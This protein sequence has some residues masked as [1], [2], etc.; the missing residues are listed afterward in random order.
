M[1]NN[2]KTKL[3]VAIIG[4][5]PIGLAAAARLTMHQQPFILF[6][7]GSQVGANFLDYHHVRLFTPWKYNIDNV[8]KN[9]LDQNGWE[10][11]KES[12]LP[13]GGDV[14]SEYLKPLADLSVLKPYIHV[15]SEV[16]SIG[17]TKMDKVKKKGRDQR[18]F[19]IQVHENNEYKSYE[20]KA[21][22]DASGVWQNH[23]PIGSEGINA[24]GE[25]KQS[26]KIYY[27]I[28]DVLHRDR[29]RYIGKKTLVVGGGHSAINTLLDLAKLQKKDSDTKLIWVLRKSTVNELY[30][31]NKKD[32]L[33]ARG[34]LGKRIQELVEANRVIIYTPFFIKSII[35]EENKKLQVLGEMNNENHS[36]NNIDEIIA[37]TGSR[38]NIK[39]LREIRYAIDPILECVPQLANYIDPNIR[40]C[41][42]VPLHGEKELKQP[43]SDFYIVGA[44]SFGRAPTFLLA[45]GYEQVRFVVAYLSGDH[46]LDQEAKL[47]LP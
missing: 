11:P 15:N 33:P 47:K 17:R 13:R 1:N 44:K 7:S 10:P 4:G 12:D 28:P 2:E 30:S 29:G 40:N 31:G 26:E 35:Q 45:I 36:I 6:E 3:P 39:F 14:V 8:A 27:G 23:N 43:E 9:L 38:P 37:N 18:S 46:K 42:Q 24:I 41:V 25:E 5:G 32:D 20:A 34:D 16:I 21:V 19:V 22:I